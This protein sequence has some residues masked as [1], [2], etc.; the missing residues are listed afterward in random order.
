MK[1]MLLNSD[2]K[3]WDIQ[4]ININLYKL[5]KFLLTPPPFPF[6]MLHSFDNRT[7]RDML[8][9]KVSSHKIA[10]LASQR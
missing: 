5:A 2:D 8:G 1:S 7:T 10:V 4:F 9:Q 6:S 3:R